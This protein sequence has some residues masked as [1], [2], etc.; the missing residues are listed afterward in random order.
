MYHLYNETN[1]DP[2]YKYRLK[3]DV[4]T[5]C[6]DYLQSILW[7]T[8]YYFHNCISWRWYYK[9]HFAPLL[10]DLCDYCMEITDIDFN[11]KDSKP[12][13]PKEQLGI[14]LPKQSFNLITDK[15]KLL[16]EY[17]YPL[18]TQVTMFMKRYY[19]ESS[20]EY[21]SLIDKFITCFY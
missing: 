6:N 20:F 13:T 1:Y 9:Y 19:W 18:D 16:D 5:L 8:Y 21:A 11:E 10:C 4:N 3:N 2:S 14:V 7:T 17:M 15:S 12:Y